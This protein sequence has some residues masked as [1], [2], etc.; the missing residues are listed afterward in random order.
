MGGFVVE[1][2]GWRWLEWISLMLSAITIVATMGMRETHKRTL[3][4]RR[5]KKRGL[6]VAG[7]SQISTAH[8]LRSMLRDAMFRPLVMLGT[9]P[10]VSFLSLYIGF[11]FAV[12]YGFFASLQLVFQEVYDFK[13]HETGLTFLSLAIGATLATITCLVMDKLIYQKKHQ[14]L[15]K[16]G[17]KKVPPEY[18]LYP[19]MVGSIGVVVSLFWFAWTARRGIS[20]ASPVVALIPFNWGNLCVFTSAAIFLIDCYGPRYGASSIAANGFVRYMF[21]MAFP[22]FIIPSKFLPMVVSI[23]KN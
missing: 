21:A 14:Q 17:I 4:E 11:N 6:K 22:L 13:P 19:A 12:L 16:Q 18:R 23:A 8:A 1:H 5:A 2:K 9:E 10:I 15:M 3:L 20:W 7:D